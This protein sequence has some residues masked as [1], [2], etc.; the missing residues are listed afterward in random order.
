M[1]LHYKISKW[2]AE[3]LEWVNHNFDNTQHILASTSDVLTDY[4]LISL[5]D[6]NIPCHAT[7]FGWWAA[8]INRNPNKIMVAP[9]DYFLDGS[10]ASR[11]ITNE[12]IQI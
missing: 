5:C 8:Y 10:D 9:K 12:F 4:S 11:L 6:H 1:E 3:Y 2:L 7:S